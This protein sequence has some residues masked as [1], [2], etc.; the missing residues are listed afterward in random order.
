MTI[1]LPGRVPSKKNSKRIIQAGGRPRLISSE[2]FLAW[3]EEMMLRVRR[4]RPKTPIARAAVTITFF[5]ESRRRFDLSNSAESVMDLLV[6]SGIL[7][8][9]SW[10]VVPE[11]TLRFGGVDLTNPRAE[12]QLLGPVGDIPREEYKSCK[13][14]ERRD[15][16]STSTMRRPSPY[17]A[18]K[19]NT[20]PTTSAVRRRTR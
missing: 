16:P 2:A 10:A 6:D 15:Q 8:D 12:V 18:I 19:V 3:H 17:I 5:A 7:A 9:D 14:S 20:T 11:L 1:L 4:Y 13:L